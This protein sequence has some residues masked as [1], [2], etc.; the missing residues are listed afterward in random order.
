M[1]GRLL[2]PAADRESGALPQAPQLTG[3][4]GIFTPLLAG[5][6]W[7]IHGVA[8]GGVEVPLNGGSIALFM[9]WAGAAIGT[10]V[11]ER[12]TLEPFPPCRGGPL[13]PNTALLSGGCRYH[14]SGTT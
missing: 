8:W 1:M 9:A 7:G 10:G 6:C 3:L 5:S 11:D 2:P 14:A 12:L 4:M 13:S